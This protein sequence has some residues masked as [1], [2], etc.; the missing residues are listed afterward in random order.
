MALN[1]KT[2]APKN[3]RSL[4]ESLL[5][6]GRIR[7]VQDY[8]FADSRGTI[9]A[10]KPGSNLK[11]D[12]AIA[13]ARDIAQER[14]ILS[15]LSPP[16]GNERV[17]DFRFE[18]GLLMVWDFGSSYLLA[19][20]GEDANPSIARMT[21]N[22][23]KEELKRDKRFKGYFVPTAAPDCSLLSEQDLGSEL[24]KHLAAL[25]QK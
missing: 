19:L 20:C 9:L 6:V 21:I 23:I 5:A 22:V 1:L 17:F 15:L 7:G 14:Q 4:L 24:S 18:G 3:R 12:M 16:D 25:K 8:L 2:V 10:R 11:D 13:C